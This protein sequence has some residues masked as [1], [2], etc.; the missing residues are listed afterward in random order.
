[1]K[2]NKIIYW[3]LTGLFLFVM[4]GSAIPDVL[5]Q[6]IAVQGFKEMQMP[7]YLLPFVGVAKILGAIAILIPGYPRIKEWAYAG[8]IFDLI[9]AVY[10]VAA[11]GKSVENWAP[12]LLFIALGVASYFYYH[13][14]QKAKELHKPNQNL[15]DNVASASIQSSFI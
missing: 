6:D 11:S 15:Q 12:M 8:L 13:K 10:S 7:A 3:I 14:L 1:M 5:V 4:V 2:K 9:G